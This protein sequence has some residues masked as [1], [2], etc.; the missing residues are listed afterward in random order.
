[1]ATYLQGVTDYIPQVQPFRPDLNFYEGVL[2]KKQA[3]YEAGYAKLSNLYGTLLNS[4]LSRTDNSERRDKFFT[5]IE[6]Q[7]KKIS[8]L[9]LSKNENVK[10]AQKVFQPILDDKYILKDIAFTR[11]YRAEMNKA[12]YFMN[13]VDEKKCGG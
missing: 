12:Q 3:Q 9:D 11:S 4:E 7:I 13:C 8:S 1:M 5:D 2:N 10:A 6:N